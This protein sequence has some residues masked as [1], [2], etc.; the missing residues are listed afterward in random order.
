MGETKAIGAKSGN[1]RQISVRL[2]PE[3]ADLL[4]KRAAEMHLKPCSLAAS[5]LARE[6]NRK[7]P[8]L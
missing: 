4:A 2:S 8:E 3:D 1:K 7:G 5:L 6:L